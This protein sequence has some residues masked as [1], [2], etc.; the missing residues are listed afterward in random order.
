ME[1]KRRLPVLNAVAGDD[2]GDP[3]RPPWQWVGF[4]AL[5]IFV[6]WIPLAWLGALVILRCGALEDAPRARGAGVA[7]GVVVA[8]RVGGYLFGRWGTRGVGVREAALA[9][10]LA[11]LVATMGAWGAAGVTW[12]A[13]VTVAVAVPPAAL[14][15]RL[16]FRRRNRLP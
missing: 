12:I 4:G 7:G 15:G 13:L 5:A 9:G 11:A 14:G 6:V 2:G 1:P 8:A 10:L 16:G 3:P